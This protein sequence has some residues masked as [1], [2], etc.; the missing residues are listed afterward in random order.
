MA[1][2]TELQSD[3]TEVLTERVPHSQPKH[4]IKDK[5][6]KQIQYQGLCMG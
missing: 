1:K 5:N 2:S 6:R 4:H 3:N